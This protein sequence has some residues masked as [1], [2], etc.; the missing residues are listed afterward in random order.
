MQ[1]FKIFGVV[2]FAAALV[3]CASTGGGTRKIGNMLSEHTGQNGRACVR[4]G[5]VRSYGVLKDGV[6]S[7]DGGRRYYLA[8]FLPGCGDLQTSAR[9]L[10]DGKFG[11]ICGMAMDKVEAGGDTCVINKMFEF[12]NRQQAFAAYDMALAQRKAPGN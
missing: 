4:L 1:G 10:F 12:E 8:T 6:V 3:S 9:A 2:A 7:I 5:D 11:E